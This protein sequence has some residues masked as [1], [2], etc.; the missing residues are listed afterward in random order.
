MR[1]AWAA[2]LMLVIVPTLDARAARAQSPAA[3]QPGRFEVA[4][5]S[6]WTGHQALG[7]NDANETTSAGGS[8]TLFSTSSDLASAAGLEGRVGVRLRR[9]LEADVEASYARPPLRIAISN[10]FESAAPAT[11]RGR[12]YQFRG[13]V[14]YL[15]ASRPT[16]PL[17]GLGARLDVRALVR[18]KG[19]AFD[20]GHYTS[21]AIGASLFV[22]F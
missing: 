16:R 6:L 4:I 1:F 21:P 22:R 5:G 8:L 18:S 12:F 11:A 19:I 7:S 2:E 20:G 9:R 15:L 13:G 14:K 10:D 3:P 17:K